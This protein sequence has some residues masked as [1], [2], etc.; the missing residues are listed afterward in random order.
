MR[1]TVGR[2]SKSGVVW[3][4]A[5]ADDFALHDANAAIVMGFEKIN[6]LPL[7]QGKKQ[8]LRDGIVTIVL[9]ENL[10]PTTTVLRTQDYGI[11]FQVGSDIGDL[12]MIYACAQ[13][14]RE[15]LAHDRKLLVL[16]R[17]RGSVGF[18][19]CVLVRSEHRIERT[20]PSQKNGCG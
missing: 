16:N 5:T 2:S 17:K 13:I 10:E 6:R 20:W 18:L 12:N 1:S 11:G 4:V 9:L 3:Y 8:L 15:L 7:V 19:V 14:Q